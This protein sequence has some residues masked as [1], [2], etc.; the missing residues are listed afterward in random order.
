[1]RTVQG[2]VPRSVTNAHRAAVQAAARG[3]GGR[4]SERTW[5]DS[6]MQAAGT[7][8]KVEFPAIGWVGAGAGTAGTRN[9]HNGC[10]AGSPGP[11]AC[12]FRASCRP[13]SHRAKT[14]HEPSRSSSPSSAAR[15]DSRGPN[16]SM[17]L[18]RTLASEPSATVARQVMACHGD[19][20]PDARPRARSSGYAGPRD[21]CCTAARSTTT[22]RARIA[23]SGEHR[24]TR[25]AVPRCHEAI[26]DDRSGGNGRS[27]RTGSD[28]LTRH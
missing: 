3:S 2:R 27:G 12:G 20:F 18:G 1:M 8:W 7:E 17:H 6:A 13:M 25:C 23:C 19:R 9:L 15:G 14:T 28:R 21:R 5:V 4:R 16:V 24:R 11:W 26:A 22:R 10:A